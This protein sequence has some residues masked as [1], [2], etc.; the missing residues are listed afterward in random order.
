VSAPS[1]VVLD[2]LAG[3]S[4]VEEQ[5]WRN[6]YRHRRACHS[7]CSPVPLPP[8][9]LRVLCAQAQALEEMNQLA[10][11]YYIGAREAA[12]IAQLVQLLGGEP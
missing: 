5:A 6:Y 4:E 7:G 12:A 1:K 10:L 8:N 3:L 11:R 9:E 2:D